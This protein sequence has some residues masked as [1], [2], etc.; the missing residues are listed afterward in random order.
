MQKR[1]RKRVIASNQYQ[2][3]GQKLRVCAIHLLRRVADQRYEI[4]RRN[5]A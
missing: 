2:V 3:L 5:V 4:I 1:H